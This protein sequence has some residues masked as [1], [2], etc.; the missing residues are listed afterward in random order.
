MDNEQAADETGRRLKLGDLKKAGARTD[1][2]TPVL[3]G[4]NMGN[5]TLALTVTMDQFREYSDVAN[6]ARIVETGGD[7][8]EIAQR[9]LDEKHARAI[10]LYMLR[11][12][13][14]GVKQNWESE[15]R[16]IPEEL[17]DLLAELGEG[18]YQ[19]LQPFTG[20]IRNCAPG[21]A[22]LDL[23]ERADGKLVLFLRQGQIIYIIDG[24]H[25]RYAYDLMMVWLREMIATSRYVSKRRGGIYIPEDREEL[26]F[27]TSELE[28]WVAVI[29]LARSHFTVDVTVH[30]GLKPEQEK[31]L[32]HDLNNLGK[33]PDAALAQAFDQANPISVFIRRHIEGE[34]LLGPNMRIADAG[35]KKGGKKLDHSDPVIYRDDL[36]TEN[37]MLFAGATNQ[38][39]ITASTVTPY[40]EYARTFWKAV[41][42][43]PHFGEAGWEKKTLMA[44]PVMIKALA[45]LAY[46]F[47]GSREKDPKYRDQ[48]LNDLAAKKIDFSPENSLWELYFMSDAERHEIDPS[49]SDYLTPDAARKS[50]AVKRDGQFDFAA[51]TRDIARYLGDLIRWKLK[52]PPRRGL[53]AL[54]TK[55][56]NQ[57][58]LPS[59]QVISPESAAA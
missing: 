57:R 14:V 16:Y 56:A 45:Q 47:H 27:T 1:F 35:S 13:L 9:P 44:E 28:I 22:D 43:Q 49:L 48:F 41:A 7:R 10:S 40:I 26:R 21:G 5:R 3:T 39:G 8:S 2:N 58:K 25:R 29:E 37:A 55:L 23:I 36:A 42:S 32:F 19:G 4:F 20:N 53:I 12:L 17:E 52:L 18:P 24:Q 50:Y 46:T 30:L 51:N 38:A 33:K 54:K 31:Q 59:T 11:G 15:D 34:G 6:E